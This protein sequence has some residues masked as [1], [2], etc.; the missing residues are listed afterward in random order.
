MARGEVRSADLGLARGSAPALRP[1]MSIVSADHC[2]RSR[3]RTVTC[4]VLATTAQLAAL[5]GNVAVPERKRLEAARADPWLRA[6]EPFERDDEPQQRESRYRIVRVCSMWRDRSAE[7]LGHCVGAGPHDR[8]RRGHDGSR[9][10]EG[11]TLTSS[12]EVQ[13]SYSEMSSIAGIA[14][15]PTTWAV[16]VSMGWWPRIRSSQRDVPARGERRTPQSRQ[17][18]RSPQPSARA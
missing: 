9:T 6:P 4:V 11:P 7:D 17:P 14:M 10:P 16:S 2:S 13:I 15:P 8:A 3:L 5:P 18:R 12:V 1:S